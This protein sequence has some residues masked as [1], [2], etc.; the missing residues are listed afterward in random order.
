MHLYEAHAVCM[1]VL[2]S[3]PNDPITSLNI[4]HLKTEL[5]VIFSLYTTSSITTSRV[6][7]NVTV[8]SVCVAAP[9]C[10]PISSYSLPTKTIAGL[11]IP[12]LCQQIVKTDN[13]RL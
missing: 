13:T 10:L 7:S 5:Y 8:P 11:L 3:D 6:E 2:P 9:W 12:T 1:R 4:L